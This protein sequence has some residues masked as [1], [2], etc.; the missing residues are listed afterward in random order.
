MFDYAMWWPLVHPLGIFID[1]QLVPLDQPLGIL[2]DWQ[3]VPFGS[4]NYCPLVNFL[5]RTTMLIKGFVTFWNVPTSF[6][7]SRASVENVGF[8]F[9]T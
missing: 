3:L 8:K 6:K 5:C 4:T 2:F 7:M 1:W 9:L